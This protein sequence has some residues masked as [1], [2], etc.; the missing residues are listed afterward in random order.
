M[1]LTSTYLNGRIEFFDAVYGPERNAQ[2]TSVPKLYNRTIGPVRAVNLYRPGRLDLSMYGTSCNHTPTGY[3]VRD[4]LGKDSS[5]DI[6]AV[7]IGGKGAHMQQ[8]LLSNL[9]EAAERLLASLH[10]SVAMDAMELATYAQLVR[11]GRRSLG[12][13]EIPL[14]APDQYKCPGLGFVPFEADTPIWWIEGRELLTGEPV[15]APAQLTQFYW[16]TRPDEARI[17]YATSGGLVFHPDRQNAILHGIYEN[18]ERD[19]IN[20]RWYCGM[21]PP[22][23][24]VD[25]VE[26]LKEHA[27]LSRPRMSTPYIP[28]VQVFLNTVDIPIPVFTAI[29][30]DRSRR[31]RAMLAGGGAWSQKERALI[32]AIFEIGQ[33]R[34]GYNLSP[35]AYDHIRPDSKLSELTDF[36]Y[37]PVYYGHEQNLSKMNWYIES[38]QVTPWNQVPTIV[39]KNQDEEYEIMMGWLR[40]NGISPLLFDF[41]T[42]CWPGVSVTKV[43]MPQVTLAHVPSH[44]YLGHPRYYEIPQK[45]GM[46]DRRLELKDLVADPLPF[47]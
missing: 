45:I 37:A 3:I 42:A 32:Q 13:A 6:L 47:P 43:Y 14:F 23:V 41:S 24:E 33:M 8:A 34:T 10:S 38:S 17:G 18:I 44:P 39:A 19:A 16:N 20:L 31:D 21:P 26:F 46:A 4:L 1:E 35:H 9:G 11:Q 28:P 40:A 27:D 22:R 5:S 30:V 36:Y 12:P 7:P 2:Y 25:I 15:M 29:T